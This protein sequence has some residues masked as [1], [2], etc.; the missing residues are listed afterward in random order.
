LA[1]S[2]QVRAAVMP[3]LPARGPFTFPAPYGTTGVRIT[4]VSDCAGGTD[5]LDYV[6]YSYWRNMNY[7]V[8][9]DS[10][11]IFLTLDRNRGGG[12]PTLFSYNKLTDQVTKV[13]PLFDSATLE[14]G[15]W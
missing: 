11:L 15:H 6:G 5:C 10:I 9:S 4:N 8:G 1:T 2:T 14:L 12:G 7:H 3:T 13:G